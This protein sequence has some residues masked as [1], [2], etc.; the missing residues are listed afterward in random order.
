MRLRRYGQSNLHQDGGV[1]VGVM[2]VF[3]FEDVNN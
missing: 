2:W 1:P 3:S